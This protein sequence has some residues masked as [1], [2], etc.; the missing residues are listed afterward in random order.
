MRALNS[1]KS[2]HGR[3]GTNN[4]SSLFNSTTI[5]ETL[6]DKITDLDGNDFH[7]PPTLSY[8]KHLDGKRDMLSPSFRRQTTDLSLLRKNVSFIIGIPTI[9]REKQTYLVE[10]IKSLIDNLNIEDMKRL[11]IVIF[12]AE[13]FDIEYVRTLSHQIEKF[14]YQHIEDGLIEIISPPIAG[15]AENPRFIANLMSVTERVLFS[16]LL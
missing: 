7:L 8:L 13:P 12:I 6:N 4:Q 10:T 14:C 9:K 15:P 5:N 11:L 1:I 3:L 2:C 16:G